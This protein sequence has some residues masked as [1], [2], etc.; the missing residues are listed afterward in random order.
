MFSCSLHLIQRL[1]SCFV[2]CLELMRNYPDNDTLTLDMSK[3][4]T[5]TTPPF[6]FINSSIGLNGGFIFP[7]SDNQSFFQ[8][9]GEVNWL[10]SSWLA[11][12]VSISQFTINSRGNGSWSGFSPGPDSGFHAINRPA[13]ALASTMDNTFFIVGGYSC[14][15]TQYSTMSTIAGGDHVKLPGIVA[16]NMTTGLWTNTSSPSHLNPLNGANGFLNSVPI[17]GPIGILL[18]AGTGT[19]NTTSQI[20]SP[21]TFENITIYEPYGK[22]WHYQNATGDIPA[23]RNAPCTVGIQGDNGTYEV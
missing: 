5:N 19:I 12:D 7:A 11:P 21:D 16:F 2:A 14:S 22:T 20:D 1:T 8:F 23:G 15:H 17:F 6:G 9:G 3:S 13:R 18:A 10:F 4:W